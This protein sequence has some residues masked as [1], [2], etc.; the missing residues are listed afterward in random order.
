M[1]DNEHTLKTW[2]NRGYELSLKIDTRKKHLEKLGGLAEMCKEKEILTYPASNT[3]ETT[4]IEKSLIRESIEEMERKLLEID[5]NTELQLYSILKNGILYTVLYHR[6]VERMSWQQISG[7]MSY[8]E[9][10]IYRLHQKGITLMA[11]LLTG[12]EIQYED[13]QVLIF[14]KGDGYS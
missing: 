7:A 1:T 6:Y 4:E 8:S 11:K 3:S 10:Q 2:L 9:R 14:P 13:N 5:K 12:Q